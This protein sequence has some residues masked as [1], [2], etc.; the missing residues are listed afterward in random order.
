MLI[1]N[2]CLDTPIYQTSSQKMRADKLLKMVKPVPELSLN[3][4]VVPSYGSKG[5]ELFQSYSDLC[6]VN[7]SSATGGVKAR[8]CAQKLW[9]KQT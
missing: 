8:V 3:S 2:I 6:F 1:L 4:F 9:E 7:I 5:V